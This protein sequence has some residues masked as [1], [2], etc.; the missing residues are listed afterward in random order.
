M[1]NNESL[2]NGLIVLG[3]LLGISQLESILGIIL[4]SVQV[5]LVLWKCGRKIYESVK[6]KRLKDVDEALKDAQEELEELKDNLK[7]KGE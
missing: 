2:E 5:I 3:S 7:D 6:D 1:S 4:L